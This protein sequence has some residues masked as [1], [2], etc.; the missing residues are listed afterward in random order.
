MQFQEYRQETAKWVSMKIA[1][2]VKINGSHGHTSI[3][4]ASDILEG[5]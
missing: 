4:T 2:S 1:V 3:A 5:F